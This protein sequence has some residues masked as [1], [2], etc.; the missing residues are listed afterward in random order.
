MPPPRNADSL[1]TLVDSHCDRAY[2]AAYRL[3]GNAADAWDLVQETFLRV[4][5]KIDLYDPAFDFGG[6]LY[7]VLYRVYLNRRRAR[8]REV[9]LEIPL[10]EGSSSADAWPAGSDET[11]EAAL[12]GR[13]RRE[14][15]QDA[16]DA[17]PDE[18]RACV[19]LVDIE[20]RS[21]AEAA[22]VLD[23]PVGSV[24]GRLFR[25]RRALRERLGRDGGQ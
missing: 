12:A 6:W 11:P 15:L 23:W 25:A 19:V 8:T 20:G 18:L 21:Y 22:D 24:S 3:T 9:S 4:M 14:Q 17:L 16:L 1:E 7:R 2:A 10:D 5:R 13:E